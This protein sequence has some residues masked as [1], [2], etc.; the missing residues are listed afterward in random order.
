[1]TIDIVATPAC[2]YVPTQSVPPPA[3]VMFIV[4]LLSVSDNVLGTAQVPQQVKLPEMD[5]KA[6]I[7][8]PP[9]VRVAPAD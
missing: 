6:L 9:H 8:V 1:M 2:V 7:S 4:V 3:C 5:E